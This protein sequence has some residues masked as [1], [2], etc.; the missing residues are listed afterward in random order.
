M[1]WGQSGQGKTYFLCRRAE[2]YVSEGKKILIIDYS[3]SFTQ[4]ELAEK[5]FKYQD[6][7]HC[8]QIDEKSP[9]TWQLRIKNR[10][11]FKKDI[12]DTFLEV[13]GCESYFQQE[14]LETAVDRIFDRQDSLRILDLMDELK[15]MLVEEEA[16]EQT[17]GNV[18]NIGRLLTRLRLYQSIESLR[19]KKG[20]VDRKEFAPISIIDVSNFPEKQRKFLTKLFLSLLW[21]ESF[22]QEVENRCDVIMLDE[23]QFLSVAEGSTLSA[24]LREGRKRG[25]ELVLSTQ[26]IKNYDQEARQVLQQAANIVIFRPTPEDCRFSA[27][28]ID[29]KG[30]GAWEG[31]LMTLERGE[32]VLK[33]TYCIENSGKIATTPIIVKI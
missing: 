15:D 27:K 29:A 20:I 32:A 6:K 3:G 28:I 5:N 25:W 13:L 26:F 10:R 21:K 8:Y 14:L 12:T 16:E 9:L 4:K 11:D 24:F 33:G 17:T 22:R 2:E 18:D 7:I 1:T 19:I 30:Y 31:L 23:I